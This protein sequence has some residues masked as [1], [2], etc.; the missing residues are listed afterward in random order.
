[1][2]WVMVLGLCGSPHDMDLKL[3][4]LLGNLS[5]SLSSIFVSEVFFLDS[6]NA[7]LEILTVSW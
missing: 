2:A 7:G 6:N 1:M 4:W 3:G 5:F